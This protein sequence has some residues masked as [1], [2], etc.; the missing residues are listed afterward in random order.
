MELS[1]FCDSNHIREKKN[2]FMIKKVHYAIKIDPDQ[3]TFREFLC[4]F[5]IHT[6]F[7]KRV[8]T[9]FNPLDMVTRIVP[10]S[11]DI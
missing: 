9:I 5:G 6:S 11:E 1:T 4:L 3:S 8:D 10:N 7:Q 2:P